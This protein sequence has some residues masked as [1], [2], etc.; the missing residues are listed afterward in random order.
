MASGMWQGLLA[1]YKSVEEKNAA[2]EAKE[3]ELR[4]KRKG[5]ALQLAAKY[6][7]KGFGGGTGDTSEG[8]TGASGGTSGGGIEHQ[9]QVL[10]TQFGVSDEAISRVAGTAGAAG[11]NQAFE[12]LE[13]T[14]KRFSDLGRD[15]P[16]EVVNNLF[17]NAVL[18]GPETDDLDFNQLEEYIGASLD[19]LEKEVVRASRASAGQAYFPEPSVL[20]APRV[21]D[22]DRIEQRAI[23]ASAQKATIEVQNINSAL[24]NIG[25][26]EETETDPNALAELAQTKA[27]LIDR[28]T[29]VKDALKSAEGD[30]GNPFGLVNLYGNEFLQEIFEAD[31]KLS[32]GVLSPIFQEARS[33]TPKRVDSL[34]QLRNLARLG[35]ISVGDK[36]EILDPA[37]GEYVLQT[38]GE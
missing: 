20:E 5:L 11:L 16:A 2:R 32:G 1:G 6:G 13:K 24:N 30:G 8:P 35:V 28:Q 26:T 7:T 12:I 10:K 17:E 15:M 3:E 21:E 22:L 9:A 34:P 4:E 14:R 38:I 36:V 31:P 33:A 27:W 37:T 25:R 19:P 29:R 18:T 23:N